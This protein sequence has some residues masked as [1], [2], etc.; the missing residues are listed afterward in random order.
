MESNDSNHTFPPSCD[1]PGTRDLNEKLR[2]FAAVTLEGRLDVTAS[3]RCSV[4]ELTRQ[5]KDA[6]GFQVVGVGY[7][8]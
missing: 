4:F 5:E 7:E 1:I 8:T 3:L 2:D 6:T